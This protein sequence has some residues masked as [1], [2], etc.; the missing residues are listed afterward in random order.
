MFA[1][2]DQINA[3][4]RS[5]GL[6]QASTGGG[7]SAWFLPAVQGVRR[8]QIAITNTLDTADLL[9]GMPLIICLESPDGVQCQCE[10]LAS[11]DSLH[12]A[13]ARFIAIGLQQFD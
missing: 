5:Q 9:P 8:W 3:Y 13:L 11:P 4:L 2:V 12:D 1:S 10:D 7:F 6:E